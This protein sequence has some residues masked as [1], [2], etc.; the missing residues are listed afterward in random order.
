MR[1]GFLTHLLWDRYGPFWVGLARAGGAEVVRPDLEAVLARLTDPRVAHAPA[2]AFRLA[3]A[4]ALALED[5]D[6]IVVPRLNPERDGGPGAAQDP[7]IAD[8]PATLER[9]RGAGPTIVPVA[10]DLT[11]RLE[12]AAVSFLARLVHEPARVRRAWAQQRAAARAPR[13]AAPEGRVRPSEQRTVAVVGQPWLATPAVARLATRAGEQPL[14]PASFAPD[15]LRAEGR[16]ADPRL[17]DTDAEALGAVRRFA[18]SAGVDEVRFVLDGGSGSD[19]WLARRAEALAHRRIEV[20]DLRSLAD[21][22]A[23]LRALIDA[24]G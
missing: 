22:E 21:D 19:A 16:R 13:R 6:L 12:T 7:W 4:A 10:A 20:V 2:V 18:R 15:D 3:V 11:G 24:V 8:L 5:V 1:V 9:V 17:I 14:T 23:R